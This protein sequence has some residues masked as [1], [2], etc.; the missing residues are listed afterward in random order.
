MRMVAMT[1]AVDARE[2]R[3]L[4]LQL[5]AIEVSQSLLH[6]SRIAPIGKCGLIGLVVHG[7]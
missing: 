6:S 4:V 5:N 2:A 7:L 3:D 1:T